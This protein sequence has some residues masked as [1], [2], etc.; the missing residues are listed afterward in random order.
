MEEIEMTATTPKFDHSK[1]YQWKADEIFSL[2]GGNLDLFKKLLML[3]LDSKEAQLII[4][5]YE[6]LKAVDAIIAKGV[7]E[8]KIKEVPKQEEAAKEIGA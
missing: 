8:G 3:D 5:K 4:A 6:A 7:E 1:S 2:T